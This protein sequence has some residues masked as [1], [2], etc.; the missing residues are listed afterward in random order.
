MYLYRIRDRFRNY[1]VSTIC[2]QFNAES[3][4]TPYHHIRIH[5][6]YLTRYIQLHFGVSSFSTFNFS[7]SNEFQS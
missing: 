7:V 5:N 3:F 1:K 4:A 2:S 6:V